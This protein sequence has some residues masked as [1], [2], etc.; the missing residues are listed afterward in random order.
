MVS[1]RFARCDFLHLLG[2]T[3]LAASFAALPAAAGPYV[4]QDLYAITP[5]PVVAEAAKVSSYAGKIGAGGVM[6]GYGASKTDFTAQGLL[7][8]PGAGPALLTPAGYSTSWGVST[9]GT[10]VVGMGL[11]ADGGQRALLWP[12]GASASVV[13]LQPTNLPDIVTSAAFA[14]SG[15]QQVGRGVSGTTHL[16]HAI[17]W[18][19]AANSAV[20]LHPAGAVAAGDWSE[21]NATDGSH[22]VGFVLNHDKGHA[23]LWSGT[24]ASWVDL[25]PSQFHGVVSST[26]RGV[27]GQYQVGFAAFDL[28]GQALYINHAMIWNGTAASAVDLQSTTVTG[29]NESVAEGI[30]GLTV[31]GYGYTTHSPYHALVWTDGT[32]GSVFDLQT[33]LPPSLVL[34]Q[35]FAVDASGNIFGTATDT[36]GLT[37]AVEWSPAAPVPEPSGLVIVAS[38]TMGLALRRRSWR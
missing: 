29:F 6:V 35:A 21:A 17:L 20:D 19:G 22:Q 31:V 12:S 7:W 32:P 37:H 3:V 14:V 36:A 38:A 5:L 33:L 23:A 24:A 27:S 34:S 16:E 10:Q 13:D 1:S 8:R 9:D 2:W 26:A 15:G 18:N 25:N 30:S 11:I 4:A 28:P